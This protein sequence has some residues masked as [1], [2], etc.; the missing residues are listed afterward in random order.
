MPVIAGWATPATYTINQGNS[1]FGT[2]NFGSNPQF[3]DAANGD[4]R[5]LVSSPAIDKGDP[6]AAPTTDI[7]GNA[8][9]SKPDL[10][11][12]DGGP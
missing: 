5:L 6:S 4:V 10:G 1:L 12:Y 8:R 7:L 9:D 11:A 2:G 3:V